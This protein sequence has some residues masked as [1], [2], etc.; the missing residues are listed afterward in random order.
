MI[1]HSNLEQA[2]REE[3]L[4]L[5]ATQQATIVALERRLADLERRLGSSGGKPMPGTKP[6]QAAAPPA[7]ARKRRSQQFVRRRARPTRQVRHALDACPGCGTR[8]Q[9]GWVQRRR[10]V[11][12]LPVAPAETVEHVFVQRQCPCCGRRCLPVAALAGVVVGQQRLGVGL[13]SLIATL[14]EAGRLPIRTIQWYLQTVHALHLSVGAI[15]AATQRLARAGATA[16]TAI[17]D[18][19]RASPAVAADETGWRESGRNGYVWTFSTPTACYFVRRRRDKT[20]VDE[21]LGDAFNGV[22]SSDFYA[23]Y[24]HYPGQKQRCWAHLWRDIHDLCALSPEDTRLQRWADHVRTV[25]AAAV[26]DQHLPDPQARRHAQ[27]RCERSLLARCHRYLADPTAV[28][29]RLCRRIVRYL[30]ELFVFVAEP[31]V[32]ADN[33]Q[34]ERSLRHLVTSRK[35]SGGTRSPQGTATKLALAT[36]FSTWHVQGL[37]P[38]HQSRLLLTSP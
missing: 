34:A 25:Y 12:E 8:L 22:L 36:L 1:P 29:A 10:E 6:Q 27:Q 32:A 33:N 35:I 7:R 4:A 30:P 14:R 24:D 23:A 17:R 9:G 11:I 31:A 13:V 3:L 2:T 18:G 37:D 15:V 26:A 5:I 19:I 20:V 38:L 16:V 28:Q 21:V